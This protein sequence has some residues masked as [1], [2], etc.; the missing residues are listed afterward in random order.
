MEFN[1]LPVISC[2]VLLVSGCAASA[3]SSVE[4]SLRAPAA[5]PAGGPAD[6]QRRPSH[7]RN[8]E[9]GPSVESVEKFRRAPLAE[10]SMVDAEPPPL[11]EGTTVLHVGDSFAG[12]LGI[13]LN[14]RLKEAGV[15]GVLRYRT[16]SYIV[17]WAHQDDL[18]TYLSQYQPD[19]VLVSLGANELEIA[20][21][22]R[23]IPAIKKIVAKIGDRPC[24]WVGVPLW[25]DKHNGLMDIVRDN[26]APCRF[27]DSAALFPDMPRG[28]DN[29]H[30]TMQAREDWAGK[31]MTW[32]ARQR[33][34]NEARAWALRTP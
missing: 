1:L 26:A 22:E 10:A 14:K 15:R 34:P 8:R 13:A 7:Q 16:A 28:H 29:I 11:P 32:L 18:E 21:P 4:P 25:S 20:E 5:E 12:A 19:L 3:A 31:V 9:S 2:A 24:V 23:R 17:E 30:P 6:P 27:M 33:R